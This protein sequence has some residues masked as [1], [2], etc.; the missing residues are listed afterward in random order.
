VANVKEKR[1]VVCPLATFAALGCAV[2]CRFAERDVR[3]ADDVGLCRVAVIES[4]LG[5]N[6]VDF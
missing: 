3:A 6:S 5:D 2:V 1:G 4:F